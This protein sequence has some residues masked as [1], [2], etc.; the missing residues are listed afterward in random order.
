MT[1]TGF[2][3]FR[4]KPKV[5][6]L[7]VLTVLTGDARLALTLAV[8]D[9]TLPIGGTQSMAVTPLTALPA[10]QVV[11]S[12][13]ARATVPASHVRQTLTLP[14]H[15]VAAALL[16]HRPVRI[17]AAGSAFVCWIGSQGISKKPVFAPVT[18]ETGGVVDALQALSCQAVAV[19]HCVGIDVVVALAQ[20][21]KPHRAVPAERVS[22][23][24][25]ITELTSLTSGARRAVGAY[26][27]LCFGDNSTT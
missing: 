23:V 11:E 27:L 22:K 21:A 2:A 26:H 25:V 7:A 24:A 6:D 5:V 13:V 10:L 9:V 8:A 12:R 14:G 4:S 3:A 20:A 17:A 1:V 18:V 15:G 16:L 19:S